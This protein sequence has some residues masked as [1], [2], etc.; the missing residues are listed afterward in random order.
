MPAKDQT[1]HEVVECGAGVKNLRKA[2]AEIDASGWEVVSVVADQ[3]GPF[4]SIFGGGD[5]FG[6]LIIIRWPP[7]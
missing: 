6:F 7:R 4:M 2:L 3:G 5:S 1:K